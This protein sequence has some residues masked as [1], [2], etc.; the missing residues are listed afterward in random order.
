MFKFCQWIFKHLWRS[1]YMF[2]VNI[3]IWYNID[4]YFNINPFFWNKSHSAMV[5]YFSHCNAGIF[6]L[7]FYLGFFSF[8]ICI[9][10]WYWPILF[11]LVLSLLDLASW[12]E[13]RSFPL[14]SVFWNNI[15]SIGIIFKGLIGWTGRNTSWNQDCRE[16][17]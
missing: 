11:I 6:L 8:R 7:V 4:G 15:K 12:M 10:K 3:L 16:K 9:L 5:C 17:Y 13:V 1:L 2:L 14:F